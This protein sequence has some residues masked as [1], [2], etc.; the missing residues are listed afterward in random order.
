MRGCTSDTSA[1]TATASPARR[2]VLNIPAAT[3]RVDPDA[4]APLVVD[5][6]LGG[7]G[8]KG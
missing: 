1:A 3:S 6:L 5:T 2:I 4:L 7:L 8:P